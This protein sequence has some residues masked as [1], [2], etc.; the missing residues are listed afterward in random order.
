MQAGPP[1]LPPN[2]STQQVQEIYQVGQAQPVPDNLSRSK[3]ITQLYLEF[4]TV[5]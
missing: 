4:A 1:P 2:L 5:H 3:H